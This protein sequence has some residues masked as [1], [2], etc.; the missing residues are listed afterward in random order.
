MKFSVFS[1]SM[2]E[3]DIEQTVKTL[4][5][6]GYDGVEW[7]VAPAPPLEKPEDYT[8]SGRYWSFNQSNIDV[9]KVE[10]LAPSVK[11]LCNKYDLEIC[12]LTTY[13]GPWDV[14]DI[15]RVLRAANILNC[16]NIRLFPPTY[17]ESENFRKLFDRTVEQIKVLEKLAARYNVRIN[18]EIHMGNII[19]SAS[20]AYRLVCNFNPDLIGII[21]DPGNMVYEGFENYR[22]GIEL[23]GE[24]L[25]HVHVKNSMWALS[26]TTKAGVKIWKP[27]WAN[28]KEGFADITKLIQILYEIGYD[29]FVSVEDFSN[30]DDT[31]TKLKSNLEFLKSIKAPGKL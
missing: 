30:N 28:M 21:F 25:A 3:Y 20:A 18:F 5:E 16:K 4:K 7:R 8:Y 15:E 9:T 22:M 6:L 24:Y 1:V 19:P 11:D 13:L 29:K 17:D 2:P 10:E 12:S 14:Q 31:Y 27:T 26:E 23:L